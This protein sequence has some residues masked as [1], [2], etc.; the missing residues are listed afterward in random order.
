M[1]Y[2]SFKY[3]LDCFLT[4]STKLISK[5]INGL[6]I[7]LIVSDKRN[8]MEQIKRAIDQFTDLRLNN[9]NNNNNI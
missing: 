8:S 3:Q 7:I 6:F 5:F 9:N 2:A 1:F 4:I